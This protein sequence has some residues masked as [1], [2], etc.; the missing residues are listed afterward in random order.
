MTLGWLSRQGHQIFCVP[1]VVLASLS[2]GKQ[3]PVER[4]SPS[5]RD[6]LDPADVALLIPVSRGLPSVPF[7]AHLL[8][9]SELGTK[10][11]VE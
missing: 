1:D 6:L 11:C 4:V 5:V 10:P 9:R 3:D 8:G 7:P 2:H